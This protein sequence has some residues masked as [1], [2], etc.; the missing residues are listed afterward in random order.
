MKTLKT[1][2]LLISTTM[3]LI[4]CEPREKEI[5][6]Y[7]DYPLC[8]NLDSEMVYSP[9]RT[10]FRIWA[11]TAIEAK[12]NLYKSGIGGDPSFEKIMT[13]DEANG[14]WMVEVE[15][16]WNGLFYAFQVKID[17]HWLDETPGIFAKAVGVN[18][19]RGVVIDMDNTDPPK[20]DNDKRPPLKNFTDI[21]IYELHVRDF[22]ISDSSGVRNKGKFLGLTETGTTNPRGDKTGI[23]HLVELGVTHVQIL[24]MFDFFS[25]D[26]TKLDKKPYNWGYDPLNYNAPEGSF[27]SDPYDPALR[28][29]EMKKMI[30]A[31]HNKGIR[32]IMDVVYNHT[33]DAPSSSFNQLVPGYF[34]RMDAAGSYSNGSACGN[35]IA[36]ERTMVR[37]FIVESVKYWVEEYH[38]DGFRFDLMGLIDVGTMAAVRQELDAIDRTIFISGEGWTAGNSTL[39]QPMQS[40]KANMPKLTRVAAFCDDMRDAIKGHYGEIT[41][42]GFVS[43]GKGKEESIKFGVVAATEHPQIDYL[44]VNYSNASWAY[45]PDQCINYVSCHDN[46]TLWDKLRLANASAYIDDVVKMHKLSNAIVLTSQGVPLLH[47]GVDI[48]RTKQGVHNSYNSPDYINQIDWMA[49]WKHRE[50]FEYY[51]SLIEMRKDH[52]AF[53]MPTA[54]MINKHLKFLSFKIPNIV[55]FTITDNANGDSWATIIVLYNG[56]NAEKTVTLP[57]GKWTVVGNGDL[58]DKY[59]ILSFKGNEV[60]I[61]AISPLI[62]VNAE[63]IR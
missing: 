40:V 23:D 63:S 51:K 62:I 13:K 5:K 41:E 33:S 61:P 27:A 12:V 2:L 47:A 34:Y 53:R 22:T 6:G 17:A 32:V 29:T 60:D 39:P 42:K 18:G 57:D 46:N 19:K 7:D 48:L 9:A 49:K 1:I 38:I 26:E 28:I 10:V 54:D 11:P 31:L 50:V 58:I 52:P 43:G 55:G 16:D 4:S 20:W 35:E 21:V 37:R 36:S 8:A 30:Q 24:P 25:I 15:G 59:G 56:N 14:T 44:K 45:E 3:L